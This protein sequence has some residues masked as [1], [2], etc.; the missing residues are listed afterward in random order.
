MAYRKALN[1]EHILSDVFDLVT[2]VAEGEHQI[3]AARFDK[4]D[5]LIIVTKHN[6]EL[7]DWLIG[8][9]NEEYEDAE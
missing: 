4:D 9:G 2:T 5:D 8:F 7:Y 6:G 3:V 1:I